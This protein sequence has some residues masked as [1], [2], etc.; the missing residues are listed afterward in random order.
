VIHLDTNFLIGA[1][2][3]ASAPQTAI[4]RWMTSGENIGV[5]AVAWA[6]FLCGPLLPPQS[7]LAGGWISAFEP[8]LPEDAKMAAELFNLAGRRRGTLADCM[9]AAT[10]IRTGA[11]LATLNDADFRPF[12]SAGLVLQQ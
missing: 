7:A 12:M 10:A 6:E 5:S 8:L 2:L 1:L 3:P 4:D 11:S 9:I